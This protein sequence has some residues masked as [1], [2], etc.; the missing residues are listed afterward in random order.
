VEDGGGGEVL[1]SKEEGEVVGLV[2]AVLAVSLGG[3][4]SL[5]TAVLDVLLEG[6]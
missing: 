3:V 1:E 2:L 4:G 6:V 5:L